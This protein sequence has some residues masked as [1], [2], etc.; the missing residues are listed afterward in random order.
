MGTHWFLVLANAMDVDDIALIINDELSIIVM[1]MSQWQNGSAINAFNAAPAGSWHHLPPRF[2][3]VLGV[4]IDVA[5]DSGGAFD[6]ALGRASEAWGFGAAP[7]VAAP[8]AATLAGV[9]GRWRDL[10]FARDSGRVL[11]PGGVQLD[12]CGVAKGYAVDR[13]ALRLRDAGATRFLVEIGGELVGQ[14]LQADGQPWWVDVE[15]PPGAEA[16]PRLRIALSGMAVATSGHY[17]RWVEVDGQRLGHS[18]DPRDGLPCSNGVAQVTVLHPRCAV[19]DALATALAVMGPEEGM[20]YADARG[21]AA[22][23]IVAQAGGWRELL[24]AGMLELSRDQ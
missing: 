13:L 15:C 19:A 21:I 9:C 1:E 2:A 10:R 12:F 5:E 24:S 22:R 20:A 8:D 11:Q 14:G 17:R 7:F 6:P 18:I 16:L 23:M 4:A 3:E